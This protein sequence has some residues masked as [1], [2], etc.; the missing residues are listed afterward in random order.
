MT[1]NELNTR[2]EKKEEKKRKATR[3]RRKG[4]E[5]KRSKEEREWT[6]GNNMASM[7]FNA[8]RRI[9]DQE[10]RFRFSTIRSRL[11]HGLRIAGRI[12][13]EGDA[14]ICLACTSTF[15]LYFLVSPSLI[16][17]IDRRYRNYSFHKLLIY[18]L[19]SLIL[20]PLVE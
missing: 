18:S 16:N 10:D 7:Y 19:L 9:L 14:T 2:E 4:K 13:G 1:N 11:F 17:V 20:M 3:K 6:K 5:R 12:D 15:L 8:H